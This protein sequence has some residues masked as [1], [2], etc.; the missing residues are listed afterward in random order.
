MAAMQS[1]GDQNWSGPVTFFLIGMAWLA[2]YFY[3]P[4]ALKRLYRKDE[5]YKSPIHVR[6]VGNDVYV[7][8]AKSEG[9][10]RPGSYVRA[11]ETD[12]LILLYTSPIMLSFVPKRD[13]T[14][15]QLS[16]VHAFL[17]RELPLRKGRNRLPAVLP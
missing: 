10:H 7:T 6:I 11:L 17:D 4:Y 5:R 12:E 1:R 2:C 16:S 3:R 8:T 13:L 15:E 9:H 14:P